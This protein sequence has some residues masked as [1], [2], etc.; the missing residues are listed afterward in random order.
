MQA[1]IL[2]CYLLIVITICSVFITSCDKKDRDPDT[3]NFAL[4]TDVRGFDP[5]FATDIRTGK[6]MALVYDNLVHFGES[7]KI[8]PGIAHSWKQDETGTKYTFYLNTS[9]RFQDGSRVTAADAVSSIK[10]VLS[11]TIGSPQSW[12][13]NRIK[14]ADAYMNKGAAF[15]LG[16][17]NINDSTLVIE[18]EEPFAPFIQYLAMPSASIVNTN[19][20]SSIKE[21][22]AGSGPWILEDWQ[23]DGQISFK[24]NEMYWGS[25]P[26]AKTLSFRILSESL[27]R[28]AE[29]EA[30]NLDLVDI[31]DIELK[32]WK[33]KNT[34][35]GRVV[36]KDELNIWY[37]GMNCSRPP[38]N[39]RRVRLAMNLALD[40]E[41]ILSLLLSGAGTQA[42]GP[43]P[44][45]L[46]ETLQVSPIPFD[47]EEAIR[48]L[49]SAGYKNGI[50]TELWVAGGSEMFHVLEAFQSYW[51]AVGIF[52]E[53][54]RSDWN[55]FKTAVR[56][57]KPDLYYLDWF[58]DYPD[59]EN[60]LYPLFHSQESMTKRNRYS[61]PK[62]DK[63][64]EM[65][66]RM[67]PGKKRNSL[68]EETHTMIKNDAPWVFLWHGRT[69]TAVQPWIE[70][71]SPKLI[72]NAERYIDIHKKEL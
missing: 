69:H 65:I 9:A 22:P 59:A 21:S 34:W 61:N 58:A 52:V 19:H 35:D 14:G 24:R 15:V 50:H 38:F 54:M 53:I 43:V 68:I 72:F 32:R 23:R 18:L 49:N 1:R 33:S 10:R 42:E 31:P 46:M 64:I 3:L 27:A 6:M 48:L 30:G 37:I 56:Q 45:Q 71:Y 57:G 60:F 11:P 29:F 70:G 28:M 41:K 63:K 26:K 8:I 36:E 40:R 7:T 55:V 17:K 66:Q 5:A 39:D 67:L 51:S 25:L 44:P 16:L 4:I 13:F 47:P 2:K 12:L 20:E 62:V